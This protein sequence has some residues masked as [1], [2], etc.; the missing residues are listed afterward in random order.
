MKPLVL[1]ASL[2]LFVFLNSFPH[3]VGMDA[4]YQAGKGVAQ[5]SLGSVEAAAKQTLPSTVPGFTTDNPSQT[6]LNAATI[7]DAA[8]RE[9][10]VSKV[11]QDLGEI[12]AKRQ[13]FTLDPTTDP[14]FKNGDEAVKNPYKSLDVKFEPEREEQTG[15]VMIRCEESAPSVDQACYSLLTLEL[16]ITPGYVVETWCC[17]GYPC[18]RCRHPRCEGI[19]INDTCYHDPNSPDCRGR[20]CES[21]YQ[22]A[23]Y[24]EIIDVVRE[25]WSDNCAH[26]EALTDQGRCQYEDKVCIDGPSTKMIQERP[27]HRECWQYRQGYECSYP[28]QNSCAGL[29]AKGCLQKTSTCKQWVQGQCAVYEQGYECPTSK[30][31]LKNIRVGVG[32]L[33]CLTGN[34]ADRSYEANGE[35]FEVLS[36]LAVLKEAQDDIR[37]NIAI[38]KGDDRRCSRNCIN[39]RDCC[40]VGKG[41][42][43]GLSL[44]FGCSANEKDL[45]IKR[46]QR[47]CVMVGTYCAKKLLGQCLEKKTT[48][49]CFGT[50]L[51][52]LIQE[53]GH[54]QLGLSW[55]SPE[56]PQCQGLSPDQLSH[57]DFSRVDFSE[58]F[59]DIADRFK[60]KGQAE[61]TQSVSAE[62]LK[63]NMT[64]LT[65][66]KA[67]AMGQSATHSQKG[68]GQ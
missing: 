40:R 2:C 5:Q 39:F 29:R 57:M 22:R 48:F 35:M 7:G 11:S 41:K 21:G 24:P 16:K 59:Q 60:P 23:E 8:H 27:I 9:A 1:L 38:F 10:S 53:A 6:A 19:E 3:L 64:R 37:Q 55:G 32:S 42:G 65:G 61:L 56:S 18:H 50:K 13:R 43:W 17:S 52:R 25:E 44:G 34:C 54:Q 28:S 36:H 63:E 67:K 26:L 15:M 45:G 31:S 46:E 30:R 68:T 47:K 14:L 66:S 62:R 58:L 33:F 12:S 4:S 49:C 20:S 51:A